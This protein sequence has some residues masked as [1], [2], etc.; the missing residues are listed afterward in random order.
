MVMLDLSSLH[1]DACCCC[2]CFCRCFP[3]ASSIAAILILMARTMATQLLVPP[4]CLPP[5]RLPTACAYLPSFALRFSALS[6]AQRRPML[7]P[8]SSVEGRKCPF[9][10]YLLFQLKL[11]LDKMMA[12]ENGAEWHPPLSAPHLF[13]TLSSPPPA[14]TPFLALSSPSVT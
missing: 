5:M 10:L 4:L 9:L 1:P 11:H 13:L 3:H 14:K 7:T 2:H 12:F 6:A 8:L